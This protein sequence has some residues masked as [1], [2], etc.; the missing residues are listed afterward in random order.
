MRASWSIQGEGG[1]G[2]G[3]GYKLRD[4]KRARLYGTGYLVYLGNTL[5]HS[6]IYSVESLEKSRVSSSKK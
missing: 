6:I 1:E 3:S 5:P 4:R 2:E